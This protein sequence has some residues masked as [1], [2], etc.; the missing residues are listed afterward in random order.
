MTPK[1]PA[2]QLAELLPCN[3]DGCKK[4]APTMCGGPQD[5]LHSHR[6][7]ARLRPALLKWYEDGVREAKRVTIADVRDEI[8]EWREEATLNAREDVILMLIDGR[9]ALIASD[10]PA[11]RGSDPDYGDA[12]REAAAGRAVCDV[13]QQV[14][15][16][17]GQSEG[18]VEV[19]QRLI[20]ERTKLRERVER[21]EKVARCARMMVEH[22]WS[23]ADDSYGMRS[24]LAALADDDST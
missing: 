20:N 6:C 3:A 4:P 21:L 9:I 12:D 5:L 11:E 15:G 22:H 10:E 1:S 8:T 2:E 7:P 17:S 14:V 18:A 13:L 19:A 24:S 16:D 23:D